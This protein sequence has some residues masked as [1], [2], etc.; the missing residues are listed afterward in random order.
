MYSCIVGSLPSF[1]GLYSSLVT[2]LLADTLF[3]G[4]NVFHCVSLYLTG[5]HGGG[6]GVVGFTVYCVLCI[7][8][9]VYQLYWFHWSHYNSL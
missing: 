2:L 5:V 7:S 8:D 3:T 9:C 4:K 1:I 6:G